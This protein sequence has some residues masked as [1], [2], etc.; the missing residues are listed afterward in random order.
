MSE[1]AN[2]EMIQYIVHRKYPDFGSLPVDLTRE[3][4]F[5]RVHGAYRVPSIEKMRKRLETAK[6]YSIFLRS[7]TPEELKELYEEETKKAVDEQIANAEHAEQQRFFNLPNA[8]ADFVHWSKAAYW[9]KLGT[10]LVQNS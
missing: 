7:K 8:V 2:L 3:E 4:K 10:D 6:A 1:D 5:F 9:T